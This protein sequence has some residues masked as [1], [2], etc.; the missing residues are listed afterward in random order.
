MS[1]PAIPACG[2]SVCV[3]CADSATPVRVIELLDGGAAR[4]DTGSTVEVVSVDLVD[5]AVGDVV[6]VHAGVAIG[7]L[8]ETPHEEDA[9]GT[10]R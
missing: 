4:V 9:S 10:S 8:D 6:L 3:T 1:T 7:K 2:H 5:A